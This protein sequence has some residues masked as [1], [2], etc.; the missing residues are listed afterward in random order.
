MSTD[1]EISSRSPRSNRPR[2]DDCAIDQSALAECLS[3]PT[4]TQHQTSRTNYKEQVNLNSIQPYPQTNIYLPSIPLRPHSLRHTHHGNIRE[5]SS[6]SHPQPQAPYP[7]P[8]TL[9]FHHPHTTYHTMPAYSQTTTRPTPPPPLAFPQRRTPTLTI[10]AKRS[11][12]ACYAQGI[13][14]VGIPTFTLY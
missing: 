1:R 11:H 6:P 10:Q 3:I 12:H 2:H 5:C 9:P 8:T 7:N 13:L 14:R 4:P